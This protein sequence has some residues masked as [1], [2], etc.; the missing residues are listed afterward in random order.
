ML[1]LT[2]G[3]LY[4]IRRQYMDIGLDAYH[5]DYPVVE[6]FDKLHLVLR[7]GTEIISLQLHVEIKGILVID[8]VHNN[9]IIRL[10]SSKLGEACLYL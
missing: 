10:E 4:G 8:T 3:A 2:H 1:C 9:K 5:T 7:I 6:R